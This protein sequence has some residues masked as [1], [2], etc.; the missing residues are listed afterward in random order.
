VTKADLQ[1]CIKA[2]LAGILLHR[3]PGIPLHPPGPI[4]SP[5]PVLMGRSGFA[6]PP[7]G[8]GHLMVVPS[9]PV[10]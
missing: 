4:N 5:L 9:L 1:G 7:L 8:V 6:Q 3:S 10:V 2:C